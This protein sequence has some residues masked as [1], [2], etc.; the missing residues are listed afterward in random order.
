[1]LLSLRSSPPAHHLIEERKKYFQACRREKW[2]LELKRR[3]FNL[4]K[5]T[6]NPVCESHDCNVSQ[7]YL[8]LVHHKDGNRKN[9]RRS[10][11][12]IVCANCHK[13]RHLHFK[14]GAWGYWSKALTP[15][16]MLRKI[17]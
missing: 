13:K 9:N 3:C 11:L 15:R 8:L 4:I 17:A 7:R 14:D 12:E 16:R 5:N 6:E 10:N 2:E 1:M